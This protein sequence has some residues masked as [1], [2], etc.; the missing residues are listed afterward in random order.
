MLWFFFSQYT[1]Y[2]GVLS[3][4]HGIFRTQ[5]LNPGLLH[6]RWILYWLSPQGSPLHTILVIEKTTVLRLRLPHLLER[7]LRNDQRV[8]FSLEVQVELVMVQPGSSKPRAA[9]PGDSLACVWCHFCSRKPKL[10]QVI[11]NHILNHCLSLAQNM[12][13]QKKR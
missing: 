4:L 13:Q 11:I 6:C 7:C 5:G 9:Q 3:L 2:F 8:K 1:V 12:C 10:L